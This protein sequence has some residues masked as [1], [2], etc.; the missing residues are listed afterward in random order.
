MG[1]YTRFKDPEAHKEIVR[2][3]Q[4]L[5]KYS[6]LYRG[7]KPYAEVLLVYPRSAVHEGE[8]EAVD[9]FKKAGRAW[10]D[11]HFL[12]DVLPDDVLTPAISARYKKVDNPIKR[13]QPVWEQ[14]SFFTAPKTVRVSAS[15]PAKGNEIT[16]HFVNYN[17]TEPKEPK[18]P[19]G[20]IK[21]EKPVAA[22]GVKA[23]F[24]LPKG[25][26]IKSLTFATPE[27][28]EVTNLKFDQ[29]GER[30]R[31]DVPKFLVYA[32]VRVELEK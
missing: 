24:V 23:N 9:K 17:R 8:I 3:Y 32:I 15:A 11:E 28:A 14:F 7:N 22:E 27:D 10:L 16:L 26:K 5:A 31:F 25:A 29:T 20:G 2:Y 21:D 30:I 13:T 1:F 4:F 12:F 19:G 18:S 6:D